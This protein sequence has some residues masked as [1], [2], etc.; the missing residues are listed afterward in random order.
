MKQLMFS[1]HDQKAE[2]FLTPFFTTTVALA[3]RMFASA[4]SDQSHDFNKFAG[5]FTLF[6][7]GDF[8]QDTAK[9]SHHATPINHGLALQ[10]IT[11]AENRAALAE[12]FNRS[13]HPIVTD[14]RESLSRI[15]GNS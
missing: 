15:K 7:I 3:I 12:D 11:I 13:E 4:A 8:D 14:A 2:A 5:D 10:H 1:V 6:E 9:L